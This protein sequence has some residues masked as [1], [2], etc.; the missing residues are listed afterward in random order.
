MAQEEPAIDADTLAQLEVTVEPHLDRLEAQDEITESD[1]QEFRE[2]LPTEPRLARVLELALPWPWS[3]LFE[4]VEASERQAA[5]WRVSHDRQAIRSAADLEHKRRFAQAAMEARGLEGTVERN[6]QTIAKSA[7]HVADAVSQESTMADEG[8]AE[9]ERALGR[10][11]E[12][13]RR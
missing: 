9:D 6:G 12:L 4:Y 5:H 1:L 13:L 8:E 11:R 3:E 7:A 2:A 10:L